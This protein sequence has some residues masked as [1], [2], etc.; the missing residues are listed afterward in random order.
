MSTVLKI[1]HL[2]SNYHRTH[3]FSSRLDLFYVGYF[4]LDRIQV[5]VMS[6]SL[7]VLKDPDPLSPR[8]LVEC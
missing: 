3:I 8:V 5:S 6:R 2:H 1:A 4:K 7:T